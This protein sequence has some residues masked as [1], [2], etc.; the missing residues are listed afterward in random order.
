VEKA[1][2][3]MKDKKPTGANDVPGNGFKMLEK[4]VSV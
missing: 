4:M 2:K 3:E 1:I